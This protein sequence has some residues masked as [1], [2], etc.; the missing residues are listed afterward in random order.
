MQPQPFPVL[1]RLCKASPSSLP[2]HL[3]VPVGS[4]AGAVARRLLLGL[5][6][7]VSLFVPV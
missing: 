1:S 3:S 6:S 2:Q 4:S 7:E 5:F